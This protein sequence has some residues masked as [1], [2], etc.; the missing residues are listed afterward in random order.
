VV[1]IFRNSQFGISLTLV[2]HIAAWVHL[3]RREWHQTQEYA[4]AAMTLATEQGFT[5]Y[6][7]RGTI[8]RGW[9]LAMQGREEEC[10]A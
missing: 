4:E 6:T 10:I 3:A 7:A 9:V 5:L 2:L 8:L 1:V